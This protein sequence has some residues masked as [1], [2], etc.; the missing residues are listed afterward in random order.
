VPDYLVTIAG[1]DLEA[2]YKAAA[3]IG[4]LKTKH[5]PTNLPPGEK[6]IVVIQEGDDEDDV[7]GILAAVLRH[8]S[9]VVDVVEV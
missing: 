5:R 2:A 8:P 9:R 6:G 4:A 1:G 7:E 3:G